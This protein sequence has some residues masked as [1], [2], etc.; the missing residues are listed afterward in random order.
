MLVGHF[1]VA[2]IAKRVEP[3]ISLGTLL[4]ATGASDFLW[5]IF[6]LAGLEH[7]QFRPGLGAAN[8]LVSSN[9]TLSHSL[10]M[11]AIWGIVFALVYLWRR[12]YPR[13]AW[14]L[15]VVVLSHWMLDFISHTRYAFGSRRSKSFWPGAL[16]FH[17]GHDCDRRRLLVV[18][19]YCL[20]PCYETKEPSW[21]FCLLARNRSSN[22]GVVWK[23][24]RTST[25]R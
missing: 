9:I 11:T 1:A 18:R 16:V 2:F 24:R 14:I 10:L 13:G 8:Y 20:Y 23:H 6:M 15:A 21:H 3:R 4:L 25:A 19:H 12:H 22:P 7:V 5:C 17:L